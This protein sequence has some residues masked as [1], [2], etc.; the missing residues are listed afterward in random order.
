VKQLPPKE[1]KEEK[2]LNPKPYKTLNFFFFFFRRKIQKLNTR[3][4]KRRGRGEV[5]FILDTL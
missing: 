1:E 2:R 3:R 4:H 5:I